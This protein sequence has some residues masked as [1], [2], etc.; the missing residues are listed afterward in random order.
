MKIQGEIKI[1]MKVEENHKKN[2][3]KDK[4]VKF[5]MKSIDTQKQ[6]IEKQTVAT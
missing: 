3:K 6:E 4:Y 2:S 1:L 5:F